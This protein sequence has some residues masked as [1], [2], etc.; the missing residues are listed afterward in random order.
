[1]LLEV[2]SCRGNRKIDLDVRK[3]LLA[4]YSGRDQ[5]TVMKHINELKNLGVPVPDKIPALYEVSPSLLTT[6][7]L[8]R[9]RS[10]TTS[11]EVEYVLLVVS[12]DEIYVTVGSDH[13][14][15]EVEKVN[16]LKAKEA[17]PKVIAP[18]VWPY[19]E[20]ANHWD[21]LVLKSVVEV[22]GS[23]KVVYQEGTLSLLL[24]PEELL[25]TFNVKEGT[26]LFSGTIPVKGG[27]LIYSS[28]FEMHLID[29]RLEREISHRYTVTV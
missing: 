20:V 26:V 15:R 3:L 19:Q 18:K 29:P 27:E 12:E 28:Y 13:T 8:I 23:R 17:C 14:D 4:G 11:G 5:G 2:E 1:M 6:G 25:R 9:V 10:K 7:D 16:V 22:G 21:E 24:S